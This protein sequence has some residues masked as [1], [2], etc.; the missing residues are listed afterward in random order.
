MCRPQPLDLLLFNYSSVNSG[1]N[2]LYKWFDGEV[3]A[4]LFCSGTCGSGHQ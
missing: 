1:G 3:G 2:T 4:S